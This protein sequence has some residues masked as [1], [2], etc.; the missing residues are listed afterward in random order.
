MNTGVANATCVQKTD[1]LTVKTDVHVTDVVRHTLDMEVLPP[2][3]GADN[4]DVR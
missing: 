2:R 4:T 1:K 3:R